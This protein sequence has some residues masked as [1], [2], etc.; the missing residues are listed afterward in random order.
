M[1]LEEGLALRALLPAELVGGSCAWGAVPS[2]FPAGEGRSPRPHPAHLRQWGPPP[3]PRSRWTPRVSTPTRQPEVP[4]IPPQGLS[5][6][7]AFRLSGAMPKAPFIF[8]SRGLVN[9]EPASGDMGM[10]G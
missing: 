4:A 7:A 8:L 1:K 3:H 10:L 6:G 9:T 5:A 2:Q